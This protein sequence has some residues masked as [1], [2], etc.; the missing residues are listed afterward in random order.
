M[1]IHS[2]YRPQ[3]NGGAYDSGN[4]YTTGVVNAGAD[5]GDITFTVPYNAPDTLYYRCQYHSGMGG[6]VTIKNLTPNDLQGITGP[7]GP[8]GIQGIQ[9][10]QGVTGNTG[11]DST[12]VGPTGATGPQGIQGIQGVTGATGAGY[13]NASI[14]GVTLQIAIPTSRSWFRF[15]TQI[16]GRVVGATGADGADGVT[17]PTG[18]TGPQGIQG[19]QGVT[20]NTGADST[21]V[22]PTGATGSQGIQ[23]VTGN[24][25]ADSTVVG[26]TGPAGPAGAGSGGSTLA[27][28]AGMVLSGIVAGVGHTLGIDPTATIHVAGI[29]ADA[30][31]VIPTGLSYG[32][33]DGAF[34]NNNSGTLQLSSSSGYYSMQVASG[35][36]SFYRDVFCED[37]LHVAGAAGISA[38]YGM[39]IGTG[40]TFPDGTFQSTASS[41]IEGVTGATGAGY[42]NA[43]IVGVTLQMQFQPAGVGLG[44]TQIIGRV[45]GA[46]GSDGSAGVT[47][48]TGA[49]GPQGIQGIQGVT[50]NTGADS[51]VVGPTGPTG[52]TEPEY[53]VGFNFDGQGT[54][55]AIQVYTDFV[56]PIEVAGTATEFIIRSPTPVSGGVRCSFRKVPSS[57]IGA[58]GAS[59]DADATTIGGSFIMLGSGEGG[60]IGVPGGSNTNLNAGDLIFMDFAGSGLK[61]KL[62]CSMRYRGS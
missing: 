11:A 61:D 46:T 36:V 13:S 35:S 62:Q 53:I 15:D 43:S 3:T 60:T 56:R 41:G 44:S 38:D 57:Y 22:G 51:T 45:V 32:W 29:S 31:I 37:E 21:V 59:L 40:I 10:I 30:G 48:P 17:G 23:G 33:S 14:V 55:L 16:I 2:I 42:S 1:V 54:D 8:Q 52:P 9:G 49:T 12:V 50:G 34:I 39:S 6:V 24:T 19:I 26:P 20:G 28:G 47:G 4:L 5:S 7:T 27:A 58:S 18:P 25:G